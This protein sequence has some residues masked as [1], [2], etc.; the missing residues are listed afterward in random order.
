MGCNKSKLNNYNYKNTKPF[1]PNINIGKVIKVYDGDTITVASKLHNNVYKFVIR[2]NRIDTP[3]LRTKN[4]KEK[5]RGIFVRDKLREKI[6]DKIIKIKVIKKEKYGRLLCEIYIN[7]E[8]I[9]DWILNNN[10]GVEY[11]GGKKVVYT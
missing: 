5:E 3:E 11:Y 7:N 2:L 6:M 4:M 8:N 10:Y 1:I 9:N